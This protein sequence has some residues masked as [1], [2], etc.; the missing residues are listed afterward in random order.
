M[1]S[2]FVLVLLA[3][4]CAA[5]AASAQTPAVPPEALPQ[6][7]GAGLRSGA[8]TSTGA[9]VPNPS[10]IPN[11]PKSSVDRDIGRKDAGRTDYGICKG[12]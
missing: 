2:R 8:I 5:S 1:T 3:V 9:T 7:G 4:A 11:A 10:A 6:N 12:C